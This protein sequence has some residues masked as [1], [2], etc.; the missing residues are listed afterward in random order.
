[1]FLMAWNYQTQIFDLEN[2][3]CLEGERPQSDGSRVRMRAELDG[4]FASH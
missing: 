2:A 4:R 3:D 1:M